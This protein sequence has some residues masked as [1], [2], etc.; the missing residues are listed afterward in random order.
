[1]DVEALA[2]RLA[3][4]S[5]AARLAGIANDPLSDNL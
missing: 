4:A 3:K 5:F 2:D 1:M